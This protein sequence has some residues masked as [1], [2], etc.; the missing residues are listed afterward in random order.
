VNRHHFFVALRA[1]G[2]ALFALVLPMSTAGAQEYPDKPVHL[3]VPFPPGGGADILART[4]AP[5][6]A[7]ALGKPIVVIRDTGMKSLTGSKRRLRYR[8][9]LMP[10]VPLVPYSS[11]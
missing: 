5:R 6:L 4:V 7:Q 1:L 11:V 9:A 8:L 3:I 2:A 10:C